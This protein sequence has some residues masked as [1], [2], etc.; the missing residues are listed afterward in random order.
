MVMQWLQRHGRAL[1]MANDGRAVGRAWLWLLPLAL[2]AAASGCG[3]GGGGSIGAR[4]VSF[5]ETTEYQASFGL[6]LVGA[7]SAY[8][9]GATG[10]GVMVAVVDTGIDRDHPEFAGAIAPASTDIVSGDPQFVEDGDSEGHGTAVSGVIAARRN[11][12]L[13]HGVA[14]QARILAVRADE[15]GS[16]VSGGCAFDQTDVAAATDYAVDRGAEVINYSLGGAPSLD[17]SLSAALARAVDARRILVLAAGNEGQAEPTL[18]ARFAADPAA[19]GL[20]I[21]VGAVDAGEQI[22]S[23]SNQAG[24]ARDHFLVAPGVN[25]L[26]PAVGGGAALVS[27]TSFAAPHVSGAAALVLQ[28][29]PFLSAAE[30]VELLLDSATDLGAPGTDPVYGRGLLNLA[31]ALGPQGALSV[32]LGSR[33]GEADAP[34]ASSALRLGPAFGPGP[35]LGAAIFLDGYGRPYWLELRDRVAAAPPGPD[36]HGWLT[37]APRPRTLAVPLGSG[38]GLAM[39]VSERSDE[40]P[41]PGAREASAGSQGDA[42]ALEL[43]VGDLAGGWPGRLVVS[44][45]SGVQN[46]FGLSSVDPEAAGGLLSQGTFASPYLALA[47]RG[48]G[49]VLAQEVAEGVAFRFGLVT[50]QADR[51]TP[52]D[53]AGNTIVIGELA[54]SWR[55]GHAVSLQLGSVDERQSLLATEAGGALGL[56]ESARTTFFGL[57]GRLA[58]ADGLALFGQGSLG[59]TDPGAAG[60]G[61]L[62]EVSVLRSS[63]FA[64]GLSGRDLLIESDRLTLA[65]AQPLRVDGGSAVLDRPVGRSFDGQILRRA[66]RVDLAPEGREIDLELGYRLALG[67]GQELGLNWLTQF[68]P[69]HRQGAGPEHAVAIRLRAG[70]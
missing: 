25:I 5:F 18:P 22:A 48:D 45:G 9:A 35:D 63:S 59:L 34:L 47:E 52:L 38:V 67:E 57:T 7:S 60:Q 6:D 21:A 20:A 8:A 15:P 65:V 44:H 37:E 40:G 49:L 16:C 32:P 56:P 26:A 12:A 3:G 39:A 51:Q 36:L 10:R 55:A 13:S 58:L 61:L 70:F 41:L 27:G 4:P 54:R 46:R 29:A 43:A 42:F 64:L 28:A 2:S 19:D 17:P 68:E 53:R 1:R 23:F 50:S 62:D 24:S 11:Q 33:V 30:V 31:A 66:D 14:F 69:G